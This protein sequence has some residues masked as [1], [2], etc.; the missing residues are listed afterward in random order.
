MRG[1]SREIYQ[2]GLVIPAVKLHRRGRLQDDVLR[3]V[4]ANVRTPVERRG[5]LNAQLAA[6]RVGETRLAEL[7]RRYGADLLTSGFAAILDYA[8]RRMR[9]RLAELPPGT[10]HGEDF[11]DDDGSSDAPVRVN[12][13]ITRSAEPLERG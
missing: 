3:L 7:A 8:E 6:L 1:N 10:Y 11:L 12:L 4:L 2:E 13:A 9:R 5:D